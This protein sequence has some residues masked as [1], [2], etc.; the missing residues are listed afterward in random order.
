[1]SDFDFHFGSPVHCQDGRR[2][3]TLERLIVEKEGLDPHSIV[4]KEDDG[5]S[6]RRFAPGA[7]YFADEVIVPIKS[8]ATAS[9][10]AVAL[11]LVTADARR[12]A[13]YLD[14]HYQPLDRSA[15]AGR[16]VALATSGP[17]TPNLTEIANKP[18][19]E[20]EVAACGNVSLAHGGRNFR[21][22]QDVPVNV[23]NSGV[24][25]ARPPRLVPPLVASP[26][27]FLPPRYHPALRTIRPR[28]DIHRLR[29]PDS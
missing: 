25:G 16:F 4:V 15:V 7:W 1:M 3:G 20:P 5:F 14:Y 2:L 27:R 11:T 29:P 6:G 10:D 18:P 9:R 8:V 12:L 28:D 13:P 17:H 21:H 23:G 24:L 22:C 19:D 26:G